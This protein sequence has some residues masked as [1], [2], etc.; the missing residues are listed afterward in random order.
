MHGNK[1]VECCRKKDD[2]FGLIAEKIEDLKKS[3]V[4][5]GV[6]SLLGRMLRQYLEVD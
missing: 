3:L 1:V 4:S 2:V 5:R 6:L